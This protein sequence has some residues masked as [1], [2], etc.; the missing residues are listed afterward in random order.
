MTRLAI[1]FSLLFAT[2]AWAELVLYCQDELATGVL[3]KNGRWQEA[4]FEKKRH[5]VKFDEKNMTVSGLGRYAMK[6]EVRYPIQAP[7]EVYCITPVTVP[8]VFSFS[9][10]SL[11][12]SYYQTSGTG[13]IANLDKP[14]TNVMYHGTCQKF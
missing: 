12:Y 3:K 1:I 14:D 2:P 6:C 5:T 10:K 4:S 7:D 13:W 11:R 9:T 8:D